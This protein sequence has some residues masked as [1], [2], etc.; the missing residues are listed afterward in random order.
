MRSLKSIDWKVVLLF[1]LLFIK[2]WTY[3][4]E[5]V[6]EKIVEVSQKKKYAEKLYQIANLQ[7]RIE[8][9]YTQST[10]IDAENMQLIFSE[11]STTEIISEVQSLIDKIARRNNIQILSIKWLPKYN[12]NEIQLI[13]CTLEASGSA[14]NIGS[15]LCELANES[16]LAILDFLKCKKSGNKTF[17]YLNFS[18]IRVGT[19]KSRK[20]METGK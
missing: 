16:K 11:K 18:L 7:D 14:F 19:P 6:T 20:S 15:F 9:A 12:K 3:L 5:R 10:R 1:T 17:V 2:L 8:K 13:P 4:N